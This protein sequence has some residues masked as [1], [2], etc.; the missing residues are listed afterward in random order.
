MD[1]TASHAARDALFENVPDIGRGSVTKGVLVLGASQG[2]KVCLALAST[3]V[4]SRLLTPYDFGLVATIAPLIALAGLLQ[5]MGL[6][7]AAIQGQRMSRALASSL[8]WLSAALGAF[9]GLTLVL[10][11]PL[12]ASFFGD[13]SLGALIA[14]FAVLPFLGSLAS[15]H[16]ALLARGMRFTS[17][18][19]IEAC[20]GMLGMSVAVVA[21]FVRR[22]AWALY[23]GALA[24]TATHVVLTWW[25]AGWMP[26]APTRK[27]GLWGS[28]RF[29]GGVS[30]FNV[31]N[32][33]TRNADS[34]IIAR[35]AGIVPL[36]IYDRA[37]KILL[38]PLQQVVAPVSRVMIPLL[39]RL[40]LDP[41]RYRRS[42]F[43]SLT[44]LL[45]GT[46]PAVLLC[47]LAAPT[48][49]ETLLGP[50]W[51]EVASVFRWL[52]IAALHQVFTNTAGWLYLS[53]GRAGDAV[54]SSAFAAATSIAAFLVGIPW[55]VVGVAMAY[56]I[57]DIV[58]R[59][60]FIW[61]VALRS[62][63]VGMG[64]FGKALLPHALACLVCAPC[65][66]SVL[67]FLEG[68]P[69]LIVAGV[70]GQAAYMTALAV[71]PTKREIL[72][73][74]VRFAIQKIRRDP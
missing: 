42:Y 73:A 56:A 68:I 61:W 67:A 31:L 63:P 20:A 49:V 27:N 66:A 7:Q 35:Q 57:S 74:N 19:S 21:A 24:S 30:A 70:F 4:M 11:A 36:G 59:A 60:P 38:F 29:G 40:N 2:L 44:L 71:F 1:S 43:E 23:W 48:I 39:S 53:Q 22:D 47:I 50:G 28:I 8:F 34:V 14:A 54:R 45:C 58:L 52:G 17:I 65:I 55:G 37:Y 32:F 13:A 41:E 72:G 25:V 51:Q 9:V 12:I 26:S 64:A 62:G 5:D 3:I 16:G 46:Q 69:S 6:S 33:L 18:A 10:F 15:Q